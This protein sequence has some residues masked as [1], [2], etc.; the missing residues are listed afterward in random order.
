MSTR[1]RLAPPALVA[2]AALAL[3]TPAASATVTAKLRVLTPDRVLDPGTTYVVGD[4]VKVPTRADAD[5]FGPPGG[6]GAQVTYDKPNAL[7]LLATAGRTTKTVAPLSLTDQFGF[8]LGICGIG[9]QKAVSGASFWYLRDNHEE[10]S[11][12]ADQVEIHN[13]DEVL[14]YLAPDDFPTPN[15]AEL[16]LQAPPRA[17]TGQPFAVSV[18]EHKC[19]TDSNTFETTCSSGPAPGVIVSGGDVP[20]TTGADGT[21][22]I[23]V[24]KAGE[25]D[26]AATRGTDIPS[27]TL[28]TCVADQLD[29]CP[30]ARGRSIV[31]SPQPDH[32]KGTAGNDSIR[33]RGGNDKVDVRQG[34]ADV[35]NCGKGRD[36][37]RLKRK[38][39][40]DGL[41]VKGS[42]ERIKRR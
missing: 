24:A 32:V 13:G 11:V 18:V 14:F 29:G 19:I 30:A 28:P 6:S 26:I 7:S 12:G 41:V 20:V 5:C 1:I 36:T 16:E 27:E 15:P 35:V 42:C 21:A 22:Q 23:A 31:G 2:L 10:A 25:A 37:V 8:G 40:N 34:G 38:R 9:G 39:A 33:T 17:L 3:L 4:G